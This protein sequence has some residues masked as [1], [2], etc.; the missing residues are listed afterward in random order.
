MN[1]FRDVNFFIIY[2]NR[3][4]IHRLVLLYL[5]K[6]KNYIC[7]MPSHLI[8]L[9]NLTLLMFFSVLV[10]SDAIFNSFIFLVKPE[11]VKSKN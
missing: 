7:S 11:N 4:L 8:F 5:I 6:K 2:V 9:P 10:V 1:N 3:I